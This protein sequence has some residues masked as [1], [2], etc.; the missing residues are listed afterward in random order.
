MR[1]AVADGFERRLAELE[2]AAVAARAGSEVRRG[3]GYVQ[4]AIAATTATAGVAGTLSLARRVSHTAAGVRLGG[5]W[6]A[7]RPGVRPA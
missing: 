7:S 3:R 5:T 1:G 2:S 4:V 6:L